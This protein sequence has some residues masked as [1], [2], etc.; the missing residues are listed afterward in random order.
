MIPKLLGAM[1]L[2]MVAAGP[3]Q[4]VDAA[5]ERAVTIVVPFAGGGPTDALGREL[6]RSLSDTLGRAVVVRN[7]EGAG[8][9]VGAERVAKSKPD[10]NTLLLSNIGHATSVWLY[11]SLRYHPA[12]DFAPLGLVAEVP[13]TLLARPGLGATSVQD[14]KAL[15][16]QGHPLTIGHAGVGSAS[17]LC[18]LL[19]MDALK[20]AFAS[21]PY[22]GTK[23]VIQDVANGH[24]DLLCD[25][26]THTL[27]PIKAGKVKVLGVTAPSRLPNLKTVPTLAESGLPGF[28]LAVWH[29]LYA[30]KGTPKDT[31]AALATALRQALQDQRLMTSFTERGVRPAQP[32]DANPEALRLKLI[33][34]IERWGPILRNAAAYAD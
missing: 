18:A 24:I 17:H 13:M 16:A 30:P 34:E 26:T 8:G 15:A 1:A 6:A 9:T 31:I 10:G 21:V 20:T 33:N 12:D 7:V 22:R 28:D 5:R 23:P 4:A 29:G 19:L 11:T 25:Q 32:D 2:V 14:V 3:A 27:T